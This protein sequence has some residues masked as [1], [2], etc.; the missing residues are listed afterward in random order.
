MATYTENYNLK[1]PSGQDAPDVEDFN[2]NAEI[3]DTV[4]KAH[5][6]NTADEYSP[7]ET[8][9]AG[10][11]VIQNN[12]LWK[13][14]QDISVAETWTPDH[15]DPTTLAAELS[16]LNSRI[17][18]SLIFNGTVFCEANTQKNITNYT[19]PDGYTLMGFDVQVSGTTAVSKGISVYHTSTNIYMCVDVAQN[20]EINIQATYLKS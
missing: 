3:I 17:M 14:K 10:R 7:D 4:L 20:Y 13:A 12:A 6:D 8:Y 18:Q 5:S 19:V 9:T 2:T 16:S 1:M 15:W 11:L